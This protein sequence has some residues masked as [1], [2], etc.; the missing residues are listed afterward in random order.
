MGFVVSVVRR[1]D[2]SQGPSRWDRCASELGP[3]KLTKAL[4]R[5]VDHDAEVLAATGSEP[6]ARHP[7]KGLQYRRLEREVPRGD[8]RL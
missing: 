6:F 8:T 2:T 5:R 3:N 1:A 4:D 7:W